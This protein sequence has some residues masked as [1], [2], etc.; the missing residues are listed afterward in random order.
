MPFSTFN[1]G[2]LLNELRLF[3]VNVKV[4]TLRGSKICNQ[5]WKDNVADKGKTLEPAVFPGTKVTRQSPG[6]YKAPT[7]LLFQAYFMG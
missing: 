1:I 6:N 3:R 5:C 7:T 2:W 4:L